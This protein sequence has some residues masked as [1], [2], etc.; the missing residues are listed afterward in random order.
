[1]K[2]I[3]CEQY[4]PPSDLIIKELPA[5]KAGEKEVVIKV[6]ACSLKLSRYLDYSREIPVQT[7]LTIYSW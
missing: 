1:M 7:C 2:A 3:V 6:K 5:L 4:G